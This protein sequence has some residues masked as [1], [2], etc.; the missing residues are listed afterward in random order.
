MHRT[1]ALCE[2]NKVGGIRT[3]S[4]PLPTDSRFL[5]AP[6]LSYDTPNVFDWSLHA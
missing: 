2:Q 6:D 1:L 4:A 5:Q 3:E